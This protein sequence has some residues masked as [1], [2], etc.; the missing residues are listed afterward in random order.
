MTEFLKQQNAHPRDQNIVFHERGHKYQILTDMK[1]YYT[2][3]TTWIHTLFPK[4]DADA[5]I[6]KMKKGRNWNPENKYWGKTNQEI[7]DEWNNNGKQVSQLGT[8]LHAYIEDFMNTE[9]NKQEYTQKDILETNNHQHPEIEWSLFE[10]FVEDFP[11]LMPYRSEWMVYDEEI[12]IAGSID[13]IYKNE[14]GS[15]SIYDWKRCKDIIYDTEWNDMASN[16]CIK[17][18]PNTNFWHYS[19]QLNMYKYILEKKYNVA[20]KDLFLVRLHPENKDNKYELHKVP[21]LVKE[22]ED[23]LNE[24]RKTD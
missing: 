1:S 8:T 5:V 10:K 12:K 22:M 18:L 19:L 14:D 2:S 15:V 6:E 16:K 7:K 4:F 20:V 24:R 3:V 9:M 17:H 11:T 21:V 13:M 23:L